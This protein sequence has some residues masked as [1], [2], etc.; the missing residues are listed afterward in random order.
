[1]ADYT[2]ILIV[3]D[4][5]ALDPAGVPLM[6]EGRESIIQDIVHMI[7]ESGLLVELLANRDPRQRRTNLIRLTLL[8]DEDLRIIPGSTR[9][10]E[11]EPGVYWLTAQT[12]K[13]GSITF[14]LG[15]S[16]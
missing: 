6:V 13:Y 15:A 12:A 16:K 14:E 9:I 3:G 11:S 5:I 4:D 2:D 8:V 1:M 10:R 7:R